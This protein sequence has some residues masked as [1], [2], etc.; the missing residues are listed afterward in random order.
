MNAIRPEKIEVT[1]EDND[2]STVSEVEAGIRDFVRNDVAYLRR[3]GPNAAGAADAAIDPHGQMHLV[4]ETGFVS[5]QDLGILGNSFDQCLDPGPI[6]LRE[7]TQ[8]IALDQV[9]CARMA[10]T[11][12]HPPI[13]VADAFRD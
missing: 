2:F 13:L 7:I 5:R 4:L 3:S 12:T 11:E 6:G 9:F 1:D 8:H 10:H